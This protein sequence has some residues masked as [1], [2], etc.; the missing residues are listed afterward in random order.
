M[1]SPTMYFP[2]RLGDAG[3]WSVIKGFQMC[4]VCLCALLNPGG[5]CNVILGSLRSLLHSRGKENAGE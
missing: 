3:I 2:S 1:N 4:H 5:Q